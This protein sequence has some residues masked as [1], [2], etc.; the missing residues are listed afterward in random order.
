MGPGNRS[1]DCHVEA[2]GSAY[3]Y[4]DGMNLYYGALKRHPGYRWLDIP[5]LVANLV[6]DLVITHTR[7]YTARIKAT[8]PEDPGPARQRIYL[9]ALQT[10]SQITIKEGVYADWPR[11]QRS[12]E[13]QGLNSPISFVPGWKRRKLTMRVGFSNGPK[14][15]SHPIGPSFWSKPDERKKKARM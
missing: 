9:E 8:Y 10:R 13:N 6:P 7:Y 4:V 3:A 14:T 1:D 2:K 5:L 15:V 12:D 11:W